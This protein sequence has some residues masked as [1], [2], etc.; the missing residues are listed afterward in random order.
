MVAH[1]QREIELLQRAV[2]RA[3]DEYELTDQEYD[4]AMDFIQRVEDGDV[5]N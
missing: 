3:Y 2:E 5:Y 1:I 4:L